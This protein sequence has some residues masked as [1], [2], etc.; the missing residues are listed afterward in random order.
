[1]HYTNCHI[2]LLEQWNH[3][4]NTKFKILSRHL[5][6]KYVH[7]M[8]LKLTEYVR[9]TISLLGKKPSEIPMFITFQR[10]YFYY[11][12]YISLKTGYFELG[13]NYDVTVTSYLWCWYLFWYVWKEEAPS[14]TMVP[15][16]CFCGVL[17]SSSQGVV[18]SPLFGKTCYKK[19]LGKT[20]VN[21]DFQ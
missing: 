2:L 10:N 4:T 20:R 5:R 13:D 21:K 16:R 11:Y 8:Q 9:I 7:A 14:Y 1:M 6:K 15:T 19:G 18:T 3:N 12:Y 17:F